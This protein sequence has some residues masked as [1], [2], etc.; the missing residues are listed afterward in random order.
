MC[1]SLN[2]MENIEPMEWCKAARK[3]MSL[4]T[5]NQMHR[6]EER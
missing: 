5:R 3:S 6:V 2:C 1:Y 4:N